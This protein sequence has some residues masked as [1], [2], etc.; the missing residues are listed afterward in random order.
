MFVRDINDLPDK[1]DNI[2]QLFVNDSQII[3]VIKTQIEIEKLQND[4]DGMGD[5]CRIWG[6]IL[7]VKKCKVI[8]FGKS[9]LG[10]LLHDS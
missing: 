4:L 1:V 3:S 5:W 9:N 10:K 8:H 6:I 7:N 2:A